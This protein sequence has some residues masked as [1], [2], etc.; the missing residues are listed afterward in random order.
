MPPGNNV[1]TRTVP[2]G[3]LCYNTCMKIL[4]IGDTHGKLNMVRD[5]MEKVTDPDMIIHTGDYYSDAQRLEE[6]YGIPVVGVSGNCDAGS[7]PA[8]AVV[9]T[10]YGKLYVTHG[11][12]EG[13][14]YKL[15]S[16]R[17]KALEEGCCCAVFGH[18]HCAMVDETDDMRF[19]NPG[20]LPQPRDGSGGSYAIIRTS[21]D[22]FDAS[23]VYYN[24]VIKKSG[25]KSGFLRNMS[26]YVDRF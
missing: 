24:T 26:N 25:T 3:H 6:M 9:E 21:E 11:A 18:T 4:V 20:S 17:Y 22:R 10:E 12:R 13:V 5:I 19:V 7:G 8:N 2:L 23:V 15:D 14:S 16:L 1:P